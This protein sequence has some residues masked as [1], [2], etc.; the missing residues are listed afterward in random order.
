MTS[1]STLGQFFTTNYKYILQNLSIPQ[2]ITD[3]IEP[4]TG[5]GDL[6]NFIDHK[7][8]YNIE[9]YDIEPKKD[10]IIQR[11]TLINPSIYN[12]K[13]IITNPPYLARNKSKDK[14]IFDKYNMND[15]Y[16][17]FY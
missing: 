15:L 10:F 9:C 1:K 3:I 4:F 8:K 12:D 5:N 6:L 16:K 2:N 14:F 7:E 11:N 13:F 17:C